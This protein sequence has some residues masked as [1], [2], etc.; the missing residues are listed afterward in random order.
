MYLYSFLRK[1]VTVSIP[2]LDKYSLLFCLQPLSSDSLVD[3]GIDLL[4]NTNV[5]CSEVLKCVPWSQYRRLS[6]EKHN[7]YST[8]K[9]RMR[10]G[11]HNILK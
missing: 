2:I 1:L 8:G 3:P 7:N 6:Q 5:M 4:L 10:I 9:S 11:V